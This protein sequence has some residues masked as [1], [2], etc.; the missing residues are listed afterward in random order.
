MLH[1]FTGRNLAGE[2]FG[3][4]LDDGGHGIDEV[5][6]RSAHPPADDKPLG[7]LQVHGI[8]GGYFPKE[9]IL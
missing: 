7:W 5:T 6:S 2:G 4:S 3:Q 1:H 8:P 9:R